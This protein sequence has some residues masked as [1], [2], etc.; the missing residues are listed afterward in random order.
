[1]SEAL[2][3]HPEVLVPVS[4]GLVFVVSSPGLERF[5]SL[6]LESLPAVE[7][8]VLGCITAEAVYAVFLN[9]LC[10]PVY[11]VVSYSLLVA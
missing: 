3:C 9:P 10:E 1:V 8:Y 6:V 7:L 4:S 5:N 2:A 11:Y